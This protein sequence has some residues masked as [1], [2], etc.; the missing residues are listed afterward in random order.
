MWIFFSPRKRKDWPAS[1]SSRAKP[2]VYPE[3]GRL[4]LHSAG[5]SLDRRR[6]SLRKQSTR[7]RPV[8]LSP[9][10]GVKRN[11]RRPAKVLSAARSPVNCRIENVRT[12]G[13]GP[14]QPGVSLPTRKRTFTNDKSDIVCAV[15]MHQIVQSNCLS[16]AIRSHPCLYLFWG[17]PLRGKSVRNGPQ[18]A[19]PVVNQR[20]RHIL[21]FPTVFREKNRANPRHLPIIGG[22]VHVGVS[23]FCETRN[24]R[25]AD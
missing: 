17:L 4:N 16:F 19:D 20:H 10:V 2:C 14:F 25:K 5:H 21:A 7:G 1:Q 9:R 8:F 24:R 13:S 22:S 23:G 3:F 6:S 15:G 11:V 12:R 18:I